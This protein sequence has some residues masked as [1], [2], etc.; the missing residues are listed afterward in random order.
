MKVNEIVFGFNPLTPSWVHL[1]HFAQDLDI[2][3]TR[4]HRKNSL[5]VFR[6]SRWDGGVLFN[7]LL[8]KT[9]S[10]QTL[11]YSLR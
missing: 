4:N 10:R 8:P 6:L 9:L 3:I 5:Y 11:S 7:P 2:K 1:V